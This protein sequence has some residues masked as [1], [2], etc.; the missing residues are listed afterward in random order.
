MGSGT[1]VAQARDLESLSEV[2]WPQLFTAYPQNPLASILRDLVSTNAPGTIS[3]AAGMPDPAL[4]P[5]ET[6]TELFN[7]N[8]GTVPLQILDIFLQKVITH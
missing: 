1:Y 7:N 6:F 3:L 4:Y 8:I 5:L 2:P